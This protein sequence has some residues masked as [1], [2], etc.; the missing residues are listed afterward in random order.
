MVGNVNTSNLKKNQVLKLIC[1]PKKNI[2]SQFIQRCDKKDPHPGKI[3]LS[4]AKPSY[5]QMEAPKNFG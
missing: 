2:G 4:E 1:P 5:K 3:A